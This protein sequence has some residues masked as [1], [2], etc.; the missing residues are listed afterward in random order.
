MTPRRRKQSSGGREVANPHTALFVSALG[1]G[2]DFPH[3]ISMPYRLVRALV[4]ASA[5]M[6]G[7]RDGA[8]GADGRAVRDATQADIRK[9]LS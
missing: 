3:L 6:R 5:D 8:A 7:A 2:V 1:L 4:E 9:F